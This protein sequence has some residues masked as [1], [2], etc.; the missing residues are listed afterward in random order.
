M[1]PAFMSHFPK[2]A[3]TELTQHISTINI[4]TTRPKYVFHQSFYSC[5]KPVTPVCVLAAA[6]VEK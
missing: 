3:P 6:S 1:S 4:P 2:Y 5:F